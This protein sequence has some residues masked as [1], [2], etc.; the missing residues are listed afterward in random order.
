HHR[1]DGGRHGPREV[2][3]EASRQVLRRRHRRGVRRDLRRRD[4]HLG[5]APRGG[6]LLD[7]PAK[8]LRSDHPRCRRAVPAGDLLPGPRR[9]GRG[10][11]ADAPRCVRPVVPARRAEFRHRRPEGRGRAV[12]PPEDGGRPGCLP[13]RHPLPEAHQPHLH[14]GPGVPPD[15]DRHL[16]D[17][18]RGPGRVP[19]GRRLDGGGRGAGAR[20]PEARGA[21]RGRGQLPLREAAR[22]RHAARP[23]G[24]LPG[25]D[26]PRGE[27]AARRVRRCRA[28]VLRRERPDARRPAPYR[29]AGP[30]RDP[31]LDD[32]PARRGRTVPGGPGRPGARL[33]ERTDVSA[34]IRIEA[35]KGDLAALAA[36]VAIVCKFKGDPEL[37][38]PVDR[39]L[40]Q[41]LVEIAKGDRF[42]GR[43]G[44]HLLW[45]AAPSDNLRSRRYL[46]LGLGERSELTLERYRRYLGDALVECDRLG[47]TSVALPLLQAGASPFP[48]REA[49]VAV[50]EGVLLGTYRFDRHR[51]E[52]RP[53]RKHLREVLLATGD[54]SP[55]EVADG[56][57]LGEITAGATNFAR[58]LVNEPAGGMTPERMVEIARQVA[59][60]E[61]IGI[62]VFEPDEL[63]GMGMGGILGVG[64]GSKHPPRLIQLEYRPEERATR[65]VALIG[66]GLTF[67]SGG[68][69]LKT[70]EGMETM[71]CDMAGSAAVLATLK[72]LP[73]LAPRAEVI[74]LMGMAE[75]MPG[76][77]AIRP[78]DIL[79]IMNGKTVEVRNTD[80]EGR[81]V[82]ADALSYASTFKDL[83]EAIDLA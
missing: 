16:G 53:G 45:H 28:R 70:S 11:R 4:G 76:G 44:R 49:A 24:A 43:A 52:P 67:D 40:A 59:Q 7:V 3:R 36:D 50:A 25:P 79:K 29:A 48:I 30:V 10:R 20:D 56:I 9:A 17:A 55:R 33:R 61:K 12:R 39:A 77:G 65:K 21:R 34:A 57:G 27:H 60:E 13:V 83:D 41:R 8:G 42:D 46:L 69:S 71:K 75:N 35:K 68:L 26:H 1:G 82:L 51:S 64:Q 78:G 23:R 38:G 72:A 32:E 6:D 31:R 14:A 54:A 18:A 81:L 19:S 2:P 37:P 15:P 80:A 63:R 62:K 74:G 73:A 5:D 66:K 47:A 58:D 22:R